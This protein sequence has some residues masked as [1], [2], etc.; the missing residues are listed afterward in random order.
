MVPNICLHRKALGS[1]IMMALDECPP[2]PSEKTY[3]KKSMVLTHKWLE[4]GIQYFEKTKP[5]YGHTQ[6]FVPICQGSVY[7]EL[8]LASIEYITQYKNPVYAIGG[9]SVGEPE[10]ELNRLVNLSCSALPVQSARYLMGV[11]TPRNILNGIEQGID[12][13]DCVLPTRNARHGIVY[14]TKGIIH[15]KNAKWQNDFTPIDEGLDLETSRSHSKAYLRH[16]F[17]SKEI[18]AAQLASLQNLRFY[19]WLMEESRNQIISNTFADW[20]RNILEII[21]QKI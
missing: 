15:I 11:G 8:R 18:L 4:A 17:I 7:D 1:D 9:L 13:F 16:L 20:K 10:S 5:L 21:D 19:S 3:A 2:Y 14:T 12:L 6:C